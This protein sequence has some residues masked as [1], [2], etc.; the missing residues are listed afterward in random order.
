MINVELY[1][2]QIHVKEYFLSCLLCLGWLHSER[3][4]NCRSETPPEHKK[5]LTD[6]K[7]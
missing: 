3:K 1:T 4:G 2:L 6:G 5:K 7:A